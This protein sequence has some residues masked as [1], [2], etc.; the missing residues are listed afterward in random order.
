MVTYGFLMLVHRSDHITAADIGHIRLTEQHGCLIIPGAGHLFT[1]VAGHLTRF[2]GGPGF[3]AMF[4]G[5]P[6][7]AGGAEVHFTAGLQWVLA[8]IQTFLLALNTIAL[9]TGGFLFRSNK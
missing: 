7:L 4:G 1:M 6:G 2:T 9:T 5:Q 8:S 3:P